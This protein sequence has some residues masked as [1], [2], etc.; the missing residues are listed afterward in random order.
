MSPIRDARLAGVVVLVHGLDI[1]VDV[2]RHHGVEPRVS[3]STPGLPRLRPAA[4]RCRSPAGRS[5]RHENWSKTVSQS[6]VDSPILKTP[7]TGPR[8]CCVSGS[9]LPVSTSATLPVSGS[10]KAS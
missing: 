5:S 4:N 3:D 2:L 8:R 6:P 1:R 10:T 7:G 9:M